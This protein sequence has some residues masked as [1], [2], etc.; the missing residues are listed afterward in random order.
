MLLREISDNTC[1]ERVQSG[2]EEYINEAADSIKNKYTAKR[3]R[4]KTDRM[5]VC[6][7]LR[8]VGQSATTGDPVYE[9]TDD[10]LNPVDVAYN[11]TKWEITVEITDEQVVPLALEKYELE[12]VFVS[13]HSLKTSQF[14]R[15][16]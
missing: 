5:I 11:L 9:L 13:K 10:S 6:D 2:Y 3:T 14:D 8:L 7:V 15:D 12:T 1:V 4:Y 16:N